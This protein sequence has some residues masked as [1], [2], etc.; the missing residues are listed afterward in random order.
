MG[1]NS[2]VFFPRARMERWQRHTTTARSHQ[3]RSRGYPWPLSSNI[4]TSLPETSRSSPVEMLAEEHEQVG[5]QQQPQ[6][7]SPSDFADFSQT[8]LNVHQELLVARNS[9]RRDADAG[10]SPI[11]TVA[12]IANTVQTP[13]FVHVFDVVQQDSTQNVL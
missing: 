2:A 13:W 6:K 10:I 9:M 12:A 4:L 8:K 1:A 5:V 3:V 11:S 7:K